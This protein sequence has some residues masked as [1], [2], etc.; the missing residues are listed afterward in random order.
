MI[1]GFSVKS[2][3]RKSNTNPTFVRD[4]SMSSTVVFVLQANGVMRVFVHLA[5]KPMPTIKK[6]NDV[7]DNH[8]DHIYP[9]RVDTV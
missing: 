7:M 9:F 6:F 3:A 2:L 1:S 4:V 5:M 8:C